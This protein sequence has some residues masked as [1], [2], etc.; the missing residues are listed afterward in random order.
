MEEHRGKIPIQPPFYYGWIVVLV[1]GLSVFFSGPGQTY[2]ISIFI[3]YYIEDFDYS[4]SLVSGIYSTATLLAGITLFM[5]GRLIDRFGQ[6]AMMVTIGINLALALFWNA[7]LLGPI[8]M[9]LGFF[10]IRLFGQGS[11]T[12]IPNTLVPQWFIRKRGRALSVMAVGGFASSALLP[13]LN[14][15]LIDSFGWRMTWGMWGFALLVVFVPLAYIF[16][17]NK[18]EHIGEVPDGTPKPVKEDMKNPNVEV[19]EK[20]WSLKEAMATRA[21]WFILF[22]VIVP[23]LVNTAVT[24]H[25][26]SIMDLQGL[27]TGV[28]AM[29]LTLMA[30]IGFPVTFVSGYLVD[31]FQVHYVLA[32]TF[33]GHIF[34]LV[35]LL[36]TD[37]WWMAVVF[38]VFWGFVNGFE[39]IVLNIVWPN[40]FGREHLGSIKGLAQTVMVVGSALGPLP[41]GLFFD[42]FGGYQEII[43]LTILFPVTAGILALLSPQ[44]KY[45]DYHA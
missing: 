31:R 40:Y 34:T 14:T 28:A 1:A 45:E 25:I 43:L 26:V 36:F 37:T 21:F 6:R 7:F 10:M 44:P 11:M 16:V 27:D 41:F 39:R 42:W 23:A 33:F 30:L 5:M 29:V 15:W 4:R 22:C 9:F 38:G 18:P 12:L 32:I 13:P 35:I 24:F 20:S 8:M 19:N 3:D 2:S 17:R